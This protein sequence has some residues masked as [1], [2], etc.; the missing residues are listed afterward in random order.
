MDN[1]TIRFTLGILQELER[2]MDGYKHEKTV[3][4]AKR[5]QKTPK[6]LI[7]QQNQLIKFDEEAN[8]KNNKLNKIYMNMIIL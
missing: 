2:L 8:K 6:Y 1:G 3:S 4:D 5:T 7:D